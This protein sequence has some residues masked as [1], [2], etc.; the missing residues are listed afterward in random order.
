MNFLSSL[1][2]DDLRQYSRLARESIAIR[3]HIDLLRWLQGDLQRFLAHEIMIAAWGDFGLGLIHYDIVSRLPG[4]RTESANAATLAPLLHGLFD[5]WVELGKAPYALGT[6]ESGFLL[7]DS[8][9][10]CALGDALQDMRSSL[11][12]GISDERGRHDC[13]YIT[14]SSN[15]DLDTTGRSAM[16]FL[17]PYLDTALRQV[18]HLPR[19]HR[20]R[21]AL[22]EADSEAPQEPTPEETPK[23]GEGHGL[24]DREAEIMHWVSI[25]KTNAE[26]GSILDISAFTVKN[27]LQRIFKKLDVYN[28]IQA[29]SKYE[30]TAPNA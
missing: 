17:L 11:V 7:N 15:A 25:G 27:H 26:T 13:L 8:L 3:R 14:F 29:V 24:S 19:Q 1:S 5:R 28:R 21:E 30:K 16:A 4:V 10:G 9:L 18:P 22:I 23:N 2:N 6:D 20:G 12:H